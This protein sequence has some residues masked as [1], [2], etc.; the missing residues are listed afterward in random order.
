MI[1]PRLLDRAV[2]AAGFFDPST[3]YAKE[4]DNGGHLM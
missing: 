4:I 3:A 1:V 2:R